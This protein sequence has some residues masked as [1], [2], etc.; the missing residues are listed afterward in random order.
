MA[1]IDDLPQV[2]VSV[3]MTGADSDC[4]EYEDPDPPTTSA[5]AGTADHSTA[6]VIESHTDAE[7]HIRYEVENSLKWLSG[8]SGVVV[9]SYIDGKEVEYTL[10]T[11]TALSRQV[12]RGIVEGVEV[13][14]IKQ[15]HVTLRKFKFSTVTRVEGRGDK[16]VDD[17][18]AAKH[19]GVIE[20]VV[21]RAVKVHNITRGDT[22]VQDFQS[23]LSKKALIG[24]TATHGTTFTNGGNIKKMPRVK[25]TYPDGERRL[26]RFFF[27]YK[28]REILENEG[29]IAQEPSPS[30]PSSPE[31]PTI[32]GLS[33]SELQRLAQERLDEIHAT[34]K[35]EKRVKRGASGDVDL[36]PSKI[37]RTD[38]DGTIDL[39][40]D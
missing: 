19:L 7:Y 21:Y 22:N 18:K 34:V 40:D 23:E 36:R 1:V 14:S 31:A 39:T 12:C 32:E 8:N 17:K 38:A 13:P 3:R 6:K 28:S 29:I 15:G 27:R 24:N 16:I 37:Y 4:P 10:R 26:A 11:D 2:K 30:P 9:R 20:V 33:Q 35:R 25:C 5:I